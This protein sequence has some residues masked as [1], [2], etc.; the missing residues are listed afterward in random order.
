M[1][2]RTMEALSGIVLLRLLQLLQLLLAVGRRK[3]RRMRMKG[4]TF[5]LFSQN[6]RPRSHHV[7]VVNRKL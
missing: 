4:E 2:G 7:V 3:G 5:D 6:P 1:W